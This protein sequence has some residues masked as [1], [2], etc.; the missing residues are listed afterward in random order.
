MRFLLLVFRI[1]SSTTTVLP[2]KLSSHQKRANVVLE[3]TFERHAWIAKHRGKIQEL[4]WH[5]DSTLTCQ[6]FFFFLSN[7]PRISCC[8]NFMCI[9]LFHVGLPI[10][11][12]VRSHIGLDSKNHNQSYHNALE[13]QQTWSSDMDGPQFVSVDRL[14][15]LHGHR[16]SR[17]CVPAIRRL[18]IRSLTSFLSRI[19]CGPLCI[20]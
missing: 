8:G 10:S 13:F 3:P 12:F 16:W 18:V 7:I 15:V 14:S 20:H 1:R 4:G 19:V 6:H 9:D 11:G 17:S 5:L 2:R